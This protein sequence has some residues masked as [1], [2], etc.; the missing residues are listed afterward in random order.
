MFLSLLGK[1]ILR[2]HPDFPIW[3]NEHYKKR[4]SWVLLRF[5][6][7]NIQKRGFWVFPRV[8]ATKMLKKTWKSLYGN[9]KKKISIKVSFEYFFFNILHTRRVKRMQDTFYGVSRVYMYLISHPFLIGLR[10]TF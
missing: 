1:K 6:S 2:R 4:L 8:L 3:G 7:T 5:L 9:K 10:A